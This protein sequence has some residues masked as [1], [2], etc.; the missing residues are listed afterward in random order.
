MMKD[1]LIRIRKPGIK[2]RAAVAACRRPRQV[3]DYV[4]A[5]PGSATPATTYNS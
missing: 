3:C 1:E 2:N 4:R 5:Q